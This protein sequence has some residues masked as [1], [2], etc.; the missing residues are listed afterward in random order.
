ML[1][2]IK[3]FLPTYLV[4]VAVPLLVGIL[5]AL[6]TKGNMDIYK[7]IATP[8]LAPPSWLFPV[9]W[10]VL[11]ILMG[12]SYAMVYMKRESDYNTFVKA[13]VIYAISLVFNFFWSILFFNARAFL[14]SFVW[15]LALLMF[16]V[17][18]IINYKKI[19]KVAAYLQIP[20]ALWVAFA[21]YLNFGIWILN[22]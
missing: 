19:D 22:R 1:K 3:K 12:I 13:T 7:E 11:Y 6:I 17:L 21:G 8:P 14:F 15:L 5:S 2:N 18:T 9:A 10:T 4:S 16:I 20:Y